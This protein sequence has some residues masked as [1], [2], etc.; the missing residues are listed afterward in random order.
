M[1]ELAGVVVEGHKVLVVNVDGEL[2]AYEDRCPHMASP[3]SE[4]VL[5]GTVLTCSSHL[6]EFDCVTGRGINPAACGLSTYA[7]RVDDGTIQV[8]ITDG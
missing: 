3:L 1:G 8:G 7:I 2:R 5:D 4:G 6:W